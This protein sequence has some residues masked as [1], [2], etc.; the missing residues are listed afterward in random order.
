MRAVMAGKLSPQAFV[1]ATD[2]VQLRTSL[3]SH[4]DA[5]NCSQRTNRNSSELLL[6]DRALVCITS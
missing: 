3:E 5:L 1:F 6:I 2:F 4:K